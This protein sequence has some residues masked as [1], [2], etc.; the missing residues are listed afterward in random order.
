MQQRYRQST[1]VILS[2]VGV[3]DTS[4][5][6]HRALTDGATV[7]VRM[8]QA[9]FYLHDRA[10]AAQFASTFDKLSTMSGLLAREVDAQHVAPVPGVRDAAVVIDARNRPRIHGRLEHLDARRVFLRVSVGRV[11]L[12]MWDLGAYASVTRAFRDAADLSATTFLS[13]PGPAAQQNASREAASRASAVFPAPRVR[14]RFGTRDAA[15]QTG[16][17]PAPA[18]ELGAGQ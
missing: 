14:R 17:G 8:G 2:L 4:V 11:V 7:G 6:A 3:Q 10:T 13:G 5:V 15:P 16:A 12:D 1:S 18:A 9:L